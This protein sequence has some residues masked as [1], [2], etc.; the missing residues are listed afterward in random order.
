MYTAKNPVI[1]TYQTFAVSS[2][3]IFPLIFMLIRQQF[4]NAYS[5]PIIFVFSCLIG[6]ICSFTLL[7]K[8]ELPKFAFPG[9]AIHLFALFMV[10]CC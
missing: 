5:F 2:V 9:I 3:M 10:T 1:V 7:L 4:T 6:L 8:F